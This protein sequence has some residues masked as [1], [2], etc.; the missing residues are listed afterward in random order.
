MPSGQPSFIL[1]HHASAIN[2]AITAQFAGN[3]R[4]PLSKRVVFMLY[5][6]KS[7][8]FYF[9]AALSHHSFFSSFTLTTC[10]RSPASPP[11]SHSLPPPLLSSSW[12]LL[13]HIACH[14][15]LCFPLGMPS[16]CSLLISHSLFTCWGFVGKIIINW[17]S[18]AYRR[19]YCTL[20][21][22]PNYKLLLYATNLW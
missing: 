5:L 18:T 13:P 16:L 14:F 11:S 6:R 8:G 15:F 4:V 17:S 22:F 19:Y 1:T 21:F 7:Q 10:V 3:R 12:Q 2:Y 20:I 9:R